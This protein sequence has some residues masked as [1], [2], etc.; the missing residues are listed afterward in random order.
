M[1]GIGIARH[2]NVIT[3][4]Y[5]PGTGTQLGLDGQSKGTPIPGEDFYRALLRIWLGEDPVDQSLKKA[6]LGQTS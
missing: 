6:L 3:L 4:N 5:I 2:G 1:D